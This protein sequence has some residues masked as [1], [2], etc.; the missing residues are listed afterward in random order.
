MKLSMIAWFTRLN[1]LI[2]DFFTGWQLREM[3][4]GFETSGEKTLMGIHVSFG[5]IF[6]IG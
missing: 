6:D 5:V 4:R 2:H 1:W 3:Y